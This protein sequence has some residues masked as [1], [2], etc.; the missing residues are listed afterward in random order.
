MTACDIGAVCGSSGKVGRRMGRRIRGDPFLKEGASRTLH[1]ELFKYA[2]IPM[3]GQ[4]GNLDGSAG[5]PT[6]PRIVAAGLRARH[7]YLL[8]SALA[9]VMLS[10]NDH[11]NQPIF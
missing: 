7:S 2:V 4:T 8:E 10:F 6:L 5:T 3:R 9:L 11:S 1:Q